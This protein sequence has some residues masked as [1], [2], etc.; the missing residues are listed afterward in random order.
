MEG[1][2]DDELKNIEFEKPLTNTEDINGF[3]LEH[4]EWLSKNSYTNQLKYK[5]EEVNKII[6][7]KEEVDKIKENFENNKPFFDEI[8]EFT[9][10]R[11]ISDALYDNVQYKV[12]DPAGTEYN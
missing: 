4:L 8:S 12:P 6:Y 7:T 10:I 3:T 5:K 2:T 11:Q 9:F 1:F